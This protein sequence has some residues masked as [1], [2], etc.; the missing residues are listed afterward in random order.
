M[1]IKNIIPFLAAVI[2]LTGFNQLSAQPDADTREYALKAAFIYRFIDYVD[3]EN[4]SENKTFK[5]AIL[6]KCP[7]TSLL[8]DI[9]KDKKAKN[10]QINV[11][12][13]KNMDEIDFCNILFVPVNCSIPFETILSKFAGKPVLIIT[14]KEGY[15]KKGAHFNFVIVE[16]KLKIEV[17]VKAINKVKLVVSS[18]LLQHG[19]IVK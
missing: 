8:L 14:E 1:T 6:E 5:I 11:E 9:A 3:W 17:N 18:F 15:G 19:I 7:I 10:K 2:V 13:Y 4:N 12:E 16:N